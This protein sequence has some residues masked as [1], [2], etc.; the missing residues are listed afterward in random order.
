MIEPRS[1]SAAA[2]EGQY[3][4]AANKGMVVWCRRHAEAQQQ[5]HTHIQQKQQ[6]Q[7]LLRCGA[8]VAPHWHGTVRAMQ[9]C[10]YTAACICIQLSY[11]FSSGARKQRAQQRKRTPTGSQPPLGHAAHAMLMSALQLSHLLVQRDKTHIR[12][13]R[14]HMYTRAHGDTHTH[15][16]K[17][18]SATEQTGA[19]VATL[20]QLIKAVCMQPYAFAVASLQVWLLLL[21]TQTHTLTQPNSQRSPCSAAASHKTRLATKM[22]QGCGCCWGVFPAQR[23][24]TV[25]CDGVFTHT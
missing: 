4:N 1:R 25:C 23:E 8:A 24:A 2:A 5:Q 18:R 21:H 19:G 9:E 15:P 11:T 12:G 10:A 16:A 14:T 7:L 3:N 13:G 20:R 22:K 6:Q 17:E